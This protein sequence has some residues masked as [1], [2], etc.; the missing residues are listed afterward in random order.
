MSPRPRRALVGLVAAAAA[1]AALPAAASAAITPALTISQSGTTA[2]ST[3]TIS[4]DAKFTSTAGD[5]PKDATFALPPGLFGNENINGGACLASSSPSAACQVGTGTLT[6]V[7]TPSQPFMVDLIAPPKAGD[8][9]GL[10]FVSGGTTTVIGEVKLTA[11]GTD[12]VFSNLAAGITEVTTSFTDLRLPTSCP[13][14]SANV[15]LTADSQQSATP[16]STTAPLNVTGCSSLPYAP[17]LTA[18]LTKDAKDSGVAIVV[19][20]TQA[21]NESASKTIVLRLPKGLTPNVGADAPCLNTTGCTVGTA[22]ATSPLVPSIA[23]ANGTVKLTAAGTTPT[24]AISFPALGLTLPGTVSLTNN[25]VTFANVP[26]VPLTSLTLN[27]TGANGQKAFNTD[28]APANITGTFTAQSGATHSASSAIK[29][30]GCNARATATGSTSGLA[31]GH[32]ALKF[33]VKEATKV[34]SVAI[35]LPAGLRF[36]HSAI[37]SKRVCTTKHG[38]KK[39]TTT[40]LIRGLGISGPAAKAVVLQGGKLVIT[41]KKAA[42]SVTISASGP[43]VSET[44]ALQTSVKKH[45]TKSLTFTLKVTD[46]KHATSTVALKLKAH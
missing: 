28:C 19:G 20:I 12:V 27:I 25:T 10:A 21:A 40:T 43:L 2:G 1:V 4:F 22:T 36:S 11:T 9:G 8:I 38:K 33:Q 32:P 15:T 16:V 23:L 46:A 24:I 26:D 45:K 7:G 34:A 3:P 41:F 17:T 18:S 14:P 35:G 37:V 31:S 5:A 6:L 13:S 29:F 44:K 42:G 39:C 30:T